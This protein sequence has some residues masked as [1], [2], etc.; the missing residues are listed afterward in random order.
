MRPE[1]REEVDYYIFSGRE[2]GTLGKRGEKV[3]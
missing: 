1:S 2:M 3:R